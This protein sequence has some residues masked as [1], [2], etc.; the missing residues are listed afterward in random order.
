MLL[1][2]SIAFIHAMELTLTGYDF[3]IFTSFTNAPN[4]FFVADTI[5]CVSANGFP[6]NGNCVTF[7]LFVQTLQA[8]M[9]TLGEYE[10]FG[11]DNLIAD[12][13]GLLTKTSL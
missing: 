12:L 2:N 7:A 6:T 9:K 1:K 13:I 4:V 11:Y 3:W 5:D 10:S 8:K